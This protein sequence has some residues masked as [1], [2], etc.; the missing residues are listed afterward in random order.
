MR[1]IPEREFDALISAA[2]DEIPDPIAQHMDNVAVFA[3][4]W[5]SEEQ[6]IDAD[7]QIL[8]IYQGVD[9]TQRGPLSYDGAMPDQIVLF[10][11]PLTRISRNEDDLKH[12]IKITVMHEVGHHFG[13]DDERLHELGWA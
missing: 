11:M 10:R 1:P 13:I 4:D 7:G 5:P 3:E 2:L 9:L 8:G 6:H 12:Q